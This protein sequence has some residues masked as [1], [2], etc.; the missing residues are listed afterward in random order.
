MN[1]IIEYFEC[2]CHDP[3]H[4]INLHYYPPLPEKMGE[5]FSKTTKKLNEE[6]NYIYLHLFPQQYMTNIFPRPIMIKEIFTKQ[7]WSHFYYSSIYKRIGIAF[8][9]LFGKF[10]LKGGILDCTIFKTEDLDRL[11]N[12]LSCLNPQ[13]TELESRPSSY[14]LEEH[15]GLYRLEFRR[16][17]SFIE[18][19][20]LNVVIQFSKLKIVKRYW[21]VF[22]YALGLNLNSYG[23]CHEFNITPKDAYILQQMI[24]E[25]KKQNF[26]TKKEKSSINE[27]N[28]KK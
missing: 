13:K 16:E 2:I 22:K 1:E 5:E 19:I 24:T 8:K 9:Y 26:I 6:E 12:T 11:Y 18:E 7:F 20:E 28:K 15:S 14:I 10:Y 21:T 27:K 23:I 3:S 25:I 17:E 4:V